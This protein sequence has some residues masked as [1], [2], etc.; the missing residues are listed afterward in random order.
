[1][2]EKTTRLET[3]PW[4]LGSKDEKTNYWPMLK[5][6]ASEEG[7]LREGFQSRSRPG[8]SAEGK[9]LRADE[10]GGGKGRLN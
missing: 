2:E 5:R 10:G 1:M 9:V 3:S 7:R 8:T 6:K 4:G